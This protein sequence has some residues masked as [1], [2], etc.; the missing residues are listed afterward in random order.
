MFEF[1][2]RL[3]KN[4]DQ[5]LT[6]VVFDDDP[7]SST[8][9]YFKP[10]RLWSY[11][12]G[13]LLLVAV[14]TLVI[15]MFTPIGS[16]LYTSE[17]SQLRQRAI[18]VSKK[19]QALQDSLQARDAQLSQMQE[20]IAY[21]EDTSF[22][23]GDKIS[24]S[25]LNTGRESSELDFSDEVS[26][27]EMLSENEIIFSKIFRQ[28]P[29]FPTDYPIEGTLTRN[30]KPTDGHYGI[31]IAVEQGTAFRAIADGAVINQDWTVDYGF[32]LHVQHNNGIITVY[33]H[34]TSLSKSIGDIVLKGDILGKAGDVGVMSSGPHLHLEIWKNGV[35][36]NPNSYLIKS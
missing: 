35:P 1:L 27:N 29:E 21:S 9:Y 8:S 10:S 34:A 11:F 20:V 5:D 31:D 16:L 2:K 4:R 33:K 17:D 26:T 25:N 14:I 7:E 36:Q 3:F 24:S 19:V 23:V 13:S 6:F 22:S 15:V 30:Y 28:A 12:Y 18:E 32:V